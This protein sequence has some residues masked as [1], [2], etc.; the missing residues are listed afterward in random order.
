MNLVRLC[1]VLLMITY[2]F[3]TYDLNGLSEPSLVKKINAIGKNVFYHKTL[4]YT[5]V[6]SRVHFVARLFLR[7]YKSRQLIRVY[8]LLDSY[9]QTCKNNVIC[10]CIFCH[11]APIYT[12]VRKSK[13]QDSY[14]HACKNQCN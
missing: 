10:K 4:I 1:F 5:H 14:I 7:K 11:N 13:K 3:H 2:N 12:Y 8:L 9:S 6:K